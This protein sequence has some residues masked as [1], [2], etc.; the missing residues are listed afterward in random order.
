MG[1]TERILY[2]LF[3]CHRI[4]KPADI[5]LHEIDNVM[6][7]RSDNENDVTRRIKTEFLT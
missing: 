4:N 3:D 6:G 1:E 7:D 2:G 5:F